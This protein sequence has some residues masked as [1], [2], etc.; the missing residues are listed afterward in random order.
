MT[1]LRVRELGRVP[2]AEANDL[3]RA[4]QC[5]G[6]RFLSLV[7]IGPSRDQL[8]D[9]GAAVC[10]E[11]VQGLDFVEVIGLV[12]AGQQ[13][14]GGTELGALVLGLEGVRELRPRRLI[15]RYR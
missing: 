3:Q 2:Y 11:Q 13:R 6:G 12:R 9:D 15:G 14:A 8:R 10:V 7:G 4:L 5:I 1:T